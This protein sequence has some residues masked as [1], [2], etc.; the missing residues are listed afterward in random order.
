VYAV[1]AG[2]MFLTSDLT[3]K[4]TFSRVEVFRATGTLVVAGGVP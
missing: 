4:G 1:E 2:V 3:K